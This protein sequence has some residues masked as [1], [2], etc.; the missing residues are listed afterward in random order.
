MKCLAAISSS[1]SLI[2]IS[3][4]MRGDAFIFFSSCSISETTRAYS[5]RQEEKSVRQRRTRA[6]NLYIDG[7]AVAERTS[8]GVRHCFS[9]RL[10]KTDKH[11]GYFTGLPTSFERR[12]AERRRLLGNANGG[13][14]LM[15]ARAEIL[16]LMKEVNH[17]VRPTRSIVRRSSPRGR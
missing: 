5:S 8:A 16:N 14:C 10:R 3:G 6:C 15:A 2:I 12:G 9:P 4:L 11:V 17:G 1:K 7:R 13:P